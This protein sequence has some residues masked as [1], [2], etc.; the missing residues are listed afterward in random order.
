MWTFNLN[1]QA[2]IKFKISKLDLMINDLIVNTKW[3]MTNYIQIFRIK[4][5]A[6]IYQNNIKKIIINENWHNKKKKL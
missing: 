3:I 6:S 4:I 2:G 5:C 1:C